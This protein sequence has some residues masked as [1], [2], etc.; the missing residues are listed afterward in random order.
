MHCGWTCAQVSR[1]I[2]HLGRLVATRDWNAMFKAQV[3]FAMWCMPA[4]A[5]AA[6]TTLAESRLA[7]AFR[8]NLTDALHQE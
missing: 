3:N 5:I 1:Q 7:L 6:L 8:S 4:A 2:G